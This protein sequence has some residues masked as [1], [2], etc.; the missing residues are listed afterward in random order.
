MEN[1]INLNKKQQQTLTWE[2]IKDEPLTKEVIEELEQQPTV[3]K[4][5]YGFTLKFITKNNDIYYHIVSPN[6]KAVE[7]Q[8]VNP[9]TIHRQILSNGERIICRYA[10]NC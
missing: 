10:F 4:T 5:R 2:V 1:Q 9:N 3:I 8:Q 6:C 7:N